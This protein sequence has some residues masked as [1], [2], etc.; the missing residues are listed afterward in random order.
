MAFE[1]PYPEHPESTKRGYWF[2]VKVITSS[3]VPLKLSVPGLGSTEQ[4]ASKD[5]Y[6]RARAK[7]PVG[8]VYV[9]EVYR[10]LTEQEFDDICM[11][12]ELDMSGPQYSAYKDQVAKGEVDEIEPI[13]QSVAPEREYR[14]L[15]LDA[16]REF[17]AAASLY[18]EEEVSAMERTLAEIHLLN[19]VGYATE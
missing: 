13:D 16:E 2:S 8:E 14:S 15:T 9:S 4:V 12:D 19:E 6:F 3:G 1:A 18:W 10:P 7:T 11:A 5:A 17:E